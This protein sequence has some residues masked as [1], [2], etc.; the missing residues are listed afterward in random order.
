MRFSL[1]EISSCCEWYVYVASALAGVVL[2]AI[3]I[4]VV[5]CL[6]KRGRTDATST[7]QMETT[8]KGSNVASVSAY[9]N[10]C[11]VNVKSDA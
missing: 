7:V 2:V 4:I 11:G 3:V 6:R 5:C 8:L 9:T 10:P 1:A